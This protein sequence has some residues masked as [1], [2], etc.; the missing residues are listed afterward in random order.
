MPAKPK[1]KQKI[2]SRFRLDGRVAAIVG[3]GGDI[4]AAAACAITDAGGSVALIGRNIDRLNES[5]AAVEQFGAEP[6]IIK[7]DARN[8]NEI[9]AA[10]NDVIDTFGK[11]DILFNNAGITSPKT[12][13]D[14]EP[15]EW[16]NIIETNINGAYNAIRFFGQE[17]IKNKYGRII[18]MGSILS[19]RGMATRSAYCA[20]KAALANLGSATAFELGEH[21]IT[22]NT[23]GAS[24]IVTNLNRDLIT[25]QPEL[26]SQIIKRTAL[27]RLG[28]LEDVTG[29]L[30]FLAS[31]AARYITGQTI[32]VDGGYTAG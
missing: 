5:A 12:I 27:G 30:V 29:T 3:G 1:N 22:V 6:L 23:I 18:N 24:V 26:Y 31:D 16:N 28:Q 14:L 20:S 19:G 15:D 7:A 2:D 32:Y 13:F 21:G 8:Q 11:V 4:G 25:A 17:M 9:R 10:C